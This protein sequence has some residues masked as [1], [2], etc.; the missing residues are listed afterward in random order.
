MIRPPD[1]PGVAFTLAADGDMRGDPG[2]RSAVSARLGIPERW[3]TA[4]QV[5]GAGV[6]EV[7]SAGEHGPGD[8][9]LT[10]VPGLPLAVFTADCLGIVVESGRGVGVAHAGWRGLAEGVI[11]ALLGAMRHAGIEP[12]R[13]A[14]GPSIGPCCYEVGPE[15]ISAFPGHVAHT[16]WGSPSVD[17]WGVAAA[18]LDPIPVWTARRCTRHEQGGFSHR[19]DGTDARMATIGW[20]AP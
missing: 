7:S 16:T 3:A 20:W 4:A 15:V 2:A 14:I 10:A 9:L 12:L 5:H 8:A 19:T 1:A 17:L 11:G 18:Q 6:V 13:A